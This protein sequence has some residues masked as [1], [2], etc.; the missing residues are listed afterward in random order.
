MNKSIKRKMKNNQIIEKPEPLEKRAI[1]SLLAGVIGIL[2]IMVSF[3]WLVILLL[4]PFIA[5]TSLIFGIS[6]LGTTKKNFAIGGIILSLIVLGASI[7]LL[8]TGGVYYILY[9][10][11]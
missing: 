9:Y 11:F 4:I 1:T 3:R 2:L 10:Y 5:I 7:Y 6:G 8:L